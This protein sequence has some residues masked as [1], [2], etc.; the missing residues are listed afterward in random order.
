MH[1]ED[2]LVLAQY[3]VADAQT[4]TTR[5]EVGPNLV[6]ATPCGQGLDESIGVEDY[7]AHI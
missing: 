3:L 4:V 7:V 6:V 1:G 5:Q 2:L